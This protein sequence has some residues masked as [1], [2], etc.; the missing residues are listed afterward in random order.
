MSS[1]SRLV[2][3]L[4]AFCMFGLA[5]YILSI[6]PVAWLAVHDFRPAGTILP[7]YEPILFA[8]QNSDLAAEWVDF[9]VASR[10][11]T[12]ADLAGF[13][14]A[15]S[16]RAGSTGIDFTMGGSI[17]IDFAITGFSS[18]EPSHIPMGGITLQTMAI[19]ITASPMPR[20]LG[21]IATILPDITL[22]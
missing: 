1:R 2:M 21:T 17:A 14:E 9:T 7:I 10:V 22:M 20:R 12:E 3:N 11:C 4:T 8:K 15:G 18:A 19:M 5:V 13:T 16:T 6:G